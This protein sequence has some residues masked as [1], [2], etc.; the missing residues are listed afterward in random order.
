MKENFD[1]IAKVVGVPPV[2]TAPDDDGEP[3][4]EGEPDEEGEEDGGDDNEEEEEVSDA[5]PSRRLRLFSQT[6]GLSVRC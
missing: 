4:E 2:A 3:E 5:R 1:Y 6:P